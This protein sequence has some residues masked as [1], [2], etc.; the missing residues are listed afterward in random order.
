MSE[1]V[2]GE[3]P[4]RQP[5]EVM[6]GAVFYMTME[7]RTQLSAGDRNVPVVLYRWCLQT[8][9]DEITKR[10]ADRKRAQSLN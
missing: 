6:E 1:H 4:L 10:S 3:I 5:G 9:V 7:F 8:E 2:N